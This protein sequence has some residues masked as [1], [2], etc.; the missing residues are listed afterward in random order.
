MA[1]SI[2]FIEEIL[3]TK[4]YGEGES[5]LDTISIHSKNIIPGSCFVAI[6]G[7]KSNGNE[8]IKEALENGASSIIMKEEYLNIYI[9]ECKEYHKTSWCICV[10]DVIESL[11]TLA[12]NWRKL[13]NVKTIGITGTIGKTTTKECIG[14]ILRYSGENPLVTKD[15]Q[16][17]KLGIALTLLRLRKE[18]TVIV[19]E[20]GISEIGEMEK[21][22]SILNPDIAI[23][24]MISK[25]H[26]RGLK[27]LETISNE[28]CKIFEFLK[29]DGFAIINGDI[30]QLTRRIY[31]KKLI[32]YGRGK[33]NHIRFGAISYGDN[34]SRST[35]S[36]MNKSFTIKL[37]SIH[38]GF[39]YNVLAAVS[40]VYCFNIQNDILKKAI[41]SFFPLP[42]RFCIIPSKKWPGTIID[43][44]YN[45]SP[46]SVKKSLYT[47]DKMNKKTKKIVVL[48]N[49]LDLGDHGTHINREIIRFLKS[50]ESITKC[51]LVGDIISQFE[52]EV[53]LWMDV[54]T[55]L[56]WNESISSVEKLLKRGFDILIK[57]ANSQQLWNIVSAID[58]EAYKNYK[59][60][61]NFYE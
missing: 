18:H 43:D 50:C 19:C 22:A 10:K 45:A 39:I 35:C 55:F 42:S 30:P 5:E 54:D 9:N 27:D 25:V 51:I 46:E 20:I 37:N 40:A 6:I 52:S 17:S 28:K 15:S 60:K 57:G 32:M 56:T 1:I 7:S 2:K 48:G 29:K 4:K 36:I 23:V 26:L 44:S 14:H 47:F 41:E 3:K 11:I 12:E 13:F 61:F 31:E 53:P 8:F 38:E 24:T 34:C 59:K 58:E 33:N 21:L 49:L 16:N